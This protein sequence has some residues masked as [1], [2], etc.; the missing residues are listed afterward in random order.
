[1]NEAARKYLAEIGGRGGAAG[2]GEAKRRPADHYARLAKLPRARKRID[3]WAGKP[4]KA[5]DVPPG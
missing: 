2:T 4:G 3:N 5:G 1:M